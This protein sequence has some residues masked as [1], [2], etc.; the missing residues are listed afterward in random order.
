[1]DGQFAEGWYKHPQLGLLKIF[2]DK[3][4]SWVY[5]CYTSNGAKPL[6]KEKDLDQWTWVL[7]EAEE[8]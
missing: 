4:K 5:Q 6:S 3:T 8:Q 7:C 2:M 1:M